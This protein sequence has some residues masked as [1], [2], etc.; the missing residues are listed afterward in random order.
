M[1][2]QD[3]WILTKDELPPDETPVLVFMNGHQVVAE[4]CW[5]HPTFEE[6]FKSFWFWDSPISPGQDWENHKILAWRHL[7]PDPVFSEQELEAA[8]EEY[9]R[10]EVES[11]Q[12]VAFNRGESR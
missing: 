3:G 2:E 6:T 8:R 5:E 1:S 7:S 4:R 10:G 9:E 11:A 12:S